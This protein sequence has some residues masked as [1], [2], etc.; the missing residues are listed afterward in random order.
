MPIA[1]WAGIGL[2]ANGCGDEV[3]PLVTARCEA[4]IECNDG[5]IC[6]EGAC[7]PKNNVSCASVEGGAAILQPGPPVVDFGR[8]GPAT[9][10]KGLSLRNIGN[11]TLT[12]FEASFSTGD[13]NMFEC[14]RCSDGRFPIELFPLRDDELEIAFTPNGVGIF[15]SELHLLSDDGEYHEIR[16][17]VRAKFDGVPDGKAFPEAIDFGYVQVGRRASRIIQVSNHGTGAA[18]LLISDVRTQPTGTTAFSVDTMLDEPHELEPKV[19]DPSAVFDIEV[20]YHP[21][22]VGRHNGEVLILTNQIRNGT[23][24]IPVTGTS[25]APPKVSIAPE[26]IEFGPIPLGRTN[27]HEV[28]IVNEGGSPLRVSHRWGATGFTTDLSA[29]PALVPSIQPG[30]HTTIEVFATATTI[31]EIAGLLIFETNDPRKPSITVPVSAL[32]QDVVGSEVVKI[33]MSFDN[34][35]SGFFGDDYRNVDMTLENPF[36]QI[37]NKQNANP[38]SWGA[39]GD[40]SW[41]AFGAGEEPERIILPNAQNDGTYRVIVQYI[42]DCASVPTRIVASLLGISVDALLGYLSGGSIMLDGDSIADAIQSL[43]LDHEGTTATVTV[44]VNGTVVQERSVGLGSKGDTVYAL[45]LIRQGGVFS[46]R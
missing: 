23:L 13:S 6:E 44:Y 36:G 1:L 19:V 41:F 20:T 16:V 33:E 2:A 43:C 21:R 32:G 46:V 39:F 34:G 17:P 7:V 15:E 3:T 11:C 5:F 10:F 8:V 9:S 38:M 35:E 26:R 4:D 40:P 25:E 29:S 24:R 28:T 14:P 31:G 45:D 22:E 12:I 30:Q 42:E 27:V 18:P 37:C